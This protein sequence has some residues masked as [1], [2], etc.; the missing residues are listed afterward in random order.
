MDLVDGV[1]SIGALGLHGSSLLWTDRDA[2]G[3]FTCELPD[4]PDGVEPLVTGLDTP[5]WLAVDGDQLVYT[6]AS[7]IERCTLPACSDSQSL[8]ANQAT[9]RF[10]SVGPTVVGWEAGGSVYFVAR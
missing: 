8:A 1:P 5:N 3:I 2:G 4:C 10:V 6:T 7:T 9:P